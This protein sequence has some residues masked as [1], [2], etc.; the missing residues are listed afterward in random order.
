M[1]LLLGVLRVRGIAKCGDEGEVG[2]KGS[3]PVDFPLRNSEI[4]FDV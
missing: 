2:G 1:L 4:E 3:G